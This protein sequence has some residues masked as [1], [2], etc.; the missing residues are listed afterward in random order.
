[1]FPFTLDAN[2]KNFPRSKKDLIFNNFIYFK[3]VKI[4]L[5]KRNCGFIN[6]N[7][8]QFIKKL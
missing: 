2:Y 3:Y 4:V 8:Y 6:T 1:M 7:M 5:N